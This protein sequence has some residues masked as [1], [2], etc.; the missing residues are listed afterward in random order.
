MAMSVAIDATPLLVEATGVDNA[1]ARLVVALGE[2]DGETRYTVLANREDRERLGSVL[3]PNF[4]VLSVSLRARPARLL[5]QQLLLPLIAQRRGVDVVHSPSFVMPLW[6]G[7]QRHVLTVH[8]MTS[9]T[10]PHVHTRLHR[11]AAFARAVTTSIRRADRIVVPSSYTKSEVLR[12]VPEVASERV[13]VIPWGVGPEFGPTAAEDVARAR[14]R[15]GL[16]RPYVLF[17]GTVEPRKNLETL[18]EA[19]RLAAE[20]E[21]IDEQLV[22]AGRL[23]WGYERLLATLDDPWFHGR[24]LRLGYVDQA[25]LPGLYAGARAFVFPALAEGFGFPPLEAMA[26]G[27]PVLASD[28]SSLRENLA[29]AAEL[30]APGDRDALAA[31]LVRLLHDEALRR[32]RR[33]AGIERAAAFRWETTAQATLDCYRRLAAERAPRPPTRP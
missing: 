22:L 10:I 5:S 14:A 19:F 31:G 25:D 11:S 3:P 23:G 28:S 4:H 24:V 21:G 30:V 17:V 7:A 6:R 8:D 33:A 1:I 29:G 15:Y 27:T 9:M 20:R 18:V 16:T 13:D 26:C 2:V 12:V 32:A